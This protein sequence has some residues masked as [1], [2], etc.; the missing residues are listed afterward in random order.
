MDSKSPLILFYLKKIF[1]LFKVS[2]KFLRF[3][4]KKQSFILILI[5]IRF[6][7]HSERSDLAWWDEQNYR[8]QSYFARRKQGACEKGK[9][10]EWN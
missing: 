8:R 9:H 4:F 6:L 2:H 5:L 7:G 3:N 10:S 1:C